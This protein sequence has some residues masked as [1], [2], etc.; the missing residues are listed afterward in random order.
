[1]N[2]LRY[3]FALALLV[4]VTSCGPTSSYAVDESEGADDTTLGLGDVFEVRVFAEDDLSARYRVS[5]DGSIDFPLIGRVLVGGL[6]PTQ[7]ADL[8]ES[9][10]R[11]GDFLR[12]PQVSVFVEEYNSKRISVLGAVQSAGSFPI[13]PGLTVVQ[14]ISLAGGFT[15]LANRDGTVLTRRVEGRMRRLSVPVDRIMAG[16]RSDIRV[17]AGDIIHVPARIL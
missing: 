16:E 15:A 1:M 4:A 2:P 8:I 6:E 13:T 9:R 7:V 10:L 11:E 5:D 3:A 12:D 17:R 14:A